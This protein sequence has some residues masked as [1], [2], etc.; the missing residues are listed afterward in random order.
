MRAPVAAL[1]LI[2]SVDGP[3][4]I[5]DSS[6]LRSDRSSPGRD[7]APGR[8]GKPDARGPDLPGTDHIASPDVTPLDQKPPPDSV[9][10]D[11]LRPL[12]APCSSPAECVSGYCVK[13]PYGGTK[14]CCH[15]NCD[16]Q[17]SDEGC[18]ADGQACVG[19]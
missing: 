19:D 13:V 6:G 15:T 18:G 5:F 17:E 3:A 11:T 8:D 14:V 9:K 7:L 10:P 16:S 12:G 1:L 4:C 2:L